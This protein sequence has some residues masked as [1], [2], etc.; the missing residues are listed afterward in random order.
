MLTPCIDTL[1][2]PRARAKTMDL[3]THG[4]LSSVTEYD[5]AQVQTRREYADARINSKTRKPTSNTARCLLLYRHACEHLLYLHRSAATHD[6]KAK[7]AE[8]I[9]FFDD[10]FS[11]EE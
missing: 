6:E 2:V 11:K 9:S 7:V 1:Q 3:V 4:P 10:K 8:D 5:Q